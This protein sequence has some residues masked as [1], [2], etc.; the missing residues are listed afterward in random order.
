M[1]DDH[2]RFAEWDAAYVIGA[3]S[4][5]DRREFE[6]HLDSCERCMRAVAEASKVLATARRA[7]AAEAAGTSS[8]TDSWTVRMQGCS[9][10]SR[11]RRP[12][13]ARKARPSSAVRRPCEPPAPA[14]GGSCAA[15][16]AC[17]R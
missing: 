7:R 9:P 16:A 10:N 3:L 5:A 12:S 2:A 1:S 6:A 11:A 8:W 14:A 13:M 17:R 15:A 4:P